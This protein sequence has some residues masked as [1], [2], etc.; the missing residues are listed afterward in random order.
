[1]R[2]VGITGR[3]GAGKS[4]VAA[5][6][7]DYELASFATPLK[8]MAAQFLIQNYDYSKQ[9]VLFF[10]NNKQRKMP[11]LGVTMR[12]LLQTLGT[13]WGRK[14]IDPFIWVNIA[15]DRIAE[16]LDED[17]VVVD[18]VRFEAEATMIRGFGGLIIHVLDGVERFDN[19]ESEAGIA[20]AKRDVVIV[21][22]GTELELM[23]KVN[24]E[25]DQ[26]YGNTDRL[27]AL[28][29]SPCWSYRA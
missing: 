21:N 12:H 8:V 28:C 4:F 3:A 29:H 25:I 26:F 17:N 23:T 2:L 6:L 20:L 15:A 5:R 7:T 16:A 9:D 13:E 24:A 18:D 27:L 14:L 1:M 10:M 22:D 11:E 19:H